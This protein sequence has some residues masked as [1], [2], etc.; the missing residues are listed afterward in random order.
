MRRF[1]L[2]SAL[3]LVIAGCDPGTDP[4]GGGLIPLDG[5]P[6]RDADGTDAGPPMSMTDAGFVDPFDPANGCGS[7][8]IPTERVPGQLLLVFDRSGSMNSA[9]SGDVSASNPSKWDRSRQAINSVLS[10]VSDELSMGL[11]LFPPEGGGDC[12]VNLGAGVPHV[13]VAPLSTSRGQIMSTLSSSS[14]GSSQ[15]PMFAA[16]RA[17]Y[18]YLDSLSG[19][20]QRGLVLVTDGAET[21]ENENRDMTMQRVADERTGSNY[22]TYAVGLTSNNNDLSTTAFNGGTPRTDTCLPECTSDLCTTD[23]DCP[24]AGTCAEIIPGAGIRFCSCATDADCVA[25][26]TCTVPPFMIFPG[27]CGGDSNCC[28]YNASE[29][30]FQTEFEMA[31]ADIASRFLDSCV[32][33]LPRGTDPSTFDPT[34]VNVGVTFGSEMRQVLGRGMS[35]DVDSWDFTDSEQR[36]IVIQGPICDRLLMESATVE[37]V[38]GCPTILI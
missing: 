4:D 18:D 30:N 1:S 27:T 38:L 34:Q 37:I 24:G 25:P 5:G 26:Q 10:S 8:A 22:L 12:N 6:P 3:L 32:F 13:P 21:C 11:M 28:H 14:A 2:L 19:P 17:G 33:E 36:S 15:T 7:S 9:P 23:A 31:L 20:G 16:L 29:G 35:S